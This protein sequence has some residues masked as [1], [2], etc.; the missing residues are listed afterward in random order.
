VPG[1]A[2]VEE[3]T[4][5][6]YL[7]RHV[8]A[9]RGRDVN[10]DEINP[11]VRHQRQPLMAV[12]EKLAHGKGSGAL[13]A[14]DLKPGH[15]FRRK[16]VLEE[17]KPERLHGLGKHQRL[18]GRDALMDVMHELYVEAQLRAQVVEHLD[19]VVYVRG[20]LEHG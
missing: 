4:A 1:R 16:T 5:R 9:A 12:Y 10:A 13:L 17:E 19:G 15:V 18:R 14:H 11:A 20:G 7:A 3:L 2:N 8:Q 6:G